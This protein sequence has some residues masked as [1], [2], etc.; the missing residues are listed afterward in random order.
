LWASHAYAFNDPFEFRLKQSAIA[1]GIDIVRK[2]KPKFNIITND[3]LIRRATRRY[4]SELRKMSVVCFT[5]KPDDIL[6]WAHYADSYKGFC[7][8]FR[9]KNDGQELSDLGIYKVNYHYEYAE[10]DFAKVWHKD[11]LASIIWTKFKA[12]EYESEFRRVMVHSEQLVDYPGSLNKIIFGLR[13][14]FEDIQLVQTILKKHSNIEY[15]RIVPA[16]D[17]YE[18]HIRGI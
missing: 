6:M 13:T 15:L 16:E 11:G 4:E 7:L 1:K 17:E 9:N 8:G 14:S 18:L 2:Q 10:K 3:E 5:S 12:W